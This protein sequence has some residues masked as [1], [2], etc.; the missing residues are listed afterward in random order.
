MGRAAYLRLACGPTRPLR[1][2]GSEAAGMG[3]QASGQLRRV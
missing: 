2:G 1:P 3:G